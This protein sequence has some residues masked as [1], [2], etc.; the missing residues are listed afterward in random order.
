MAST[1]SSIPEGT[2]RIIESVRGAEESALEAARKFADTVNGVFT[3]PTKDGPRR[4]IID[5]IFKMTEQPVEASTRLAQEIVKTTK[6]V[7]TQGKDT[8]GSST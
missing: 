3:E 2:S 7:L 5:S 8:A 6:D 1:E 4:Q